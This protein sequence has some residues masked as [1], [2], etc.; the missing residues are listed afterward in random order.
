MKRYKLTVLLSTLV[1]TVVS[2]CSMFG[3]R[4]GYEKLDYTV[5]DKVQDVEI[6]R[7][8]DRIVAEAS[9][10]KSDNE[11]FMTLFKYISGENS[12]K[13]SVAMTTPV[14]VSKDSV[15]IEMT[16][17]VEKSNSIDNEVTMRFF[18]PHTFSINSAP[19]PNETRIRIF[20]LPEETYAVL[21]YS[22]SGSNERFQTMSE[23]LIKI[24]SDSKWKPVS[25]PSFLGYDPPFTIPFLRKNEAIV[26]VQLQH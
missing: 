18:L 10:M 1:M 17:P 11:A 6:R 12:S 14:Q 13:E 21:T 20:I 5:I 16:T 22:W 4:T 24:I 2:G 23:S 15:K 25:E 8:S 3:I 9:K 26:K 19:K 7:Y